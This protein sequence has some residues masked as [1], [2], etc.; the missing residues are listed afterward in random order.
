[1]KSDFERTLLEARGTVKSGYLMLINNV[2]KATALITFA[3]S[4]LVTF[5][6][7]SFESFTGESFTGTLLLMLLSSYL[8]FFSME[9]AGEKLGM[10]EEAFVKVNEKYKKLCA[11]L[12]PESI[13]KLRDFCIAYS[14]EELKYR[15]ESTLTAAGLSAEDLLRYKNGEA[16]CRADRRVFRAVEKMRGHNLTPRELLSEDR[17]QRRAELENPE[18]KKLLSLFMKMIPTTLCMIFTVS[19]I[20]TAKETL[21][22]VSIIEGIIKLSS[23]PVIA[24]RGYFNGYSYATERLPSYIDMKSRLLENFLLKAGVVCE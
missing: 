19:I 18:G 12:P 13:G 21:D 2:G 4:V 8:I 1:M 17:C 9:S 10:Q 7:V 6:E 3:V 23:L 15:K 14:K 11:A 20:L 24:M 5:T 22:A 16:Y